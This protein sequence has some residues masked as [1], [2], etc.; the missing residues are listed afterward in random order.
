MRVLTCS[1]F[2]REPACVWTCLD[3][4]LLYPSH[5]LTYLLARLWRVQQWQRGMERM[6]NEAARQLAA[7]AIAQCVCLL[8]QDLLQSC[9]RGGGVILEDRSVAFAYRWHIYIYICISTS[10]YGNMDPFT[11]TA[12]NISLQRF[13]TSYDAASAGVSTAL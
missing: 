5:P 3:L 1:R 11:S 6:S 9:S 8:L 2:A 12:I 7:E 4:P 10:T 13:V